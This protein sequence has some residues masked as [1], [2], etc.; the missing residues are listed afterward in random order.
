MR[1]GM[2][3]TEHAALRYSVQMNRSVGDELI[4]VFGENTVDS[5]AQSLG[6]GMP[7]VGEHEYIRTL[8]RRMGNDPEAHECAH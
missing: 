6:G 4:D 1:K 2:Y 8:V 7:F 5:S 3:L